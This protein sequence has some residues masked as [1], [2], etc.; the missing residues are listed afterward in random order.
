MA[1]GIRNQQTRDIG[2]LDEKIILQRQAIHHD[3]N[4]GN[5]PTWGEWKRKWCKVKSTT[6]K[7][8]QPLANAQVIVEDVRFYIVWDRDIDTVPAPVFRIVYPETPENGSS[9]MNYKVDSVNRVGGATYFL[10]IMATGTG[11]EVS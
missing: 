1:N 9:R 4:H 8:W 5:S 10:E 11:V 3:R 6:G 2:R 7:K